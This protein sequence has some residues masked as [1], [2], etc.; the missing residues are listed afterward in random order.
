MF[1]TFSAEI[2][3]LC[4]YMDRL[5]SDKEG[6]VICLRLH[7]VKWFSNIAY[8]FEFSSNGIYNVHIYARST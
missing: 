6:E 5:C 7:L 1:Y 8:G 3:Y 2:L 4:I